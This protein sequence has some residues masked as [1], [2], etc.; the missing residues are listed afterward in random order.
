VLTVGTGGASLIYNVIPIN[1]NLV[2]E[3]TDID[4]VAHR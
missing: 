2:D 3:G 1:E 4:S